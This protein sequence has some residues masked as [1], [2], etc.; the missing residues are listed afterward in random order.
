MPAYSHINDFNKAAQS[1]GFSRHRVAYFNQRQPI[2]KRHLVYSGHLAN[3]LEQPTL[4]IWELVQFL[5][6]SL[7]SASIYQK[8]A[9]N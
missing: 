5:L 3:L 9:M 6:H 4:I 1:N 7:I 2:P 8:W